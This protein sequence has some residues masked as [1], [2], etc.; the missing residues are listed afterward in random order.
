VDEFDYILGNLVR[1]G[2]LKPLDVYVDSPLAKEATRIYLA[3][4]EYFDEEATRLFTT[5]LEALYS[6]GAKKPETS[7]SIPIRM[8]GLRKAFI[9]RG[10]I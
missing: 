1:E 6:I 8:R 9:T 5:G 2:R 3:H 4:R 7:I 10:K